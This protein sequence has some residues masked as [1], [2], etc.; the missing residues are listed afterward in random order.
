M[1]APRGRNGLPPLSVLLVCH[2]YPPHV[3]GIEE[4]ARAEAQGLAAEGLAVTVLTSSPGAAAAGTA[5]PGV[6]VVR[7]PA[8]NSFERFGVPFP[9][10]PSPSPASQLG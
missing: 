3:G 9:C 10:S 5:D 8:L 6:R 2:Y 1:T 4:V 7:V